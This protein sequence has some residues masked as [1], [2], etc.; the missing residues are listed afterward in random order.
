MG[1]VAHSKTQEILYKM[2]LNMTGLTGFGS[3]FDKIADGEATVPPEGARFDIDFEGTIEGPKV[4]GKVVGVDYMNMRA[5]GRSNLN[6]HLKIETEDGQNISGQLTGSST[7]RADNSRIIDFRENGVLF[8]SSENYKWVN[9]LQVWASGT[10][11]RDTGKIEL[12]AYA[13]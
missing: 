4:K 6:I 9:G 10:V 13:D 7:L 1:N 8:T 12:T 11:D 5:D 2:D 3:D